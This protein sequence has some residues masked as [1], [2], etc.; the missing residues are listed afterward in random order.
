MR[1]SYYVNSWE[2]LILS[3]HE[4]FLFCHFM[5]DYDINKNRN[6]KNPGKELCLKQCL[7]SH[8]ITFRQSR[9]FSFL[10]QLLINRILI[11]VLK[12]FVKSF[13][14]ATGNMLFP[15]P[16]Q[17]FYDLYWQNK[18]DIKL[19]KF[20]HFLIFLSRRNCEIIDNN[21]KKCWYFAVLVCRN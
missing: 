10:T 1:D 13:F 3:F 21:F 5:R 4:R 17:L 16:N 8:E 12:L 20:N 11:E 19:V 2:I 15:S 14:S 9:T 18:F 6:R 7:C